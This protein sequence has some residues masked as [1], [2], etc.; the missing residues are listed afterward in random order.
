MPAARDPGEPGHWRRDG[1]AARVDGILCHDGNR[2]G[3]SRLRRQRHVQEPRQRPR[4]PELLVIDLHERPR[5]LRI[6]GQTTPPAMTRAA[7]ATLGAQ[8]RQGAPSSPT[9]R[10]PSPAWRSSSHPGTCRSR[11]RTPWSHMEGSADV[12]GCRA[13]A[14]TR[15]VR[16]AGVRTG[17]ARRAQEPQRDPRQWPSGARLARMTRVGAYGPAGA[18]DLA[19]DAAQSLARST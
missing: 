15:H 12:K 17:G 11:G 10:A 5:R 7:A 4:Q 18:P 6:N 13:P 9:A 2:A 3:V 16:G 19:A 14:L 1:E 8:L